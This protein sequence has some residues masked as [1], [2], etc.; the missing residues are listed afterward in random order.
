M[1]STSSGRRPSTSPPQGGAQGTGTHMHILNNKSVR[2]LRRFS[3][4]KKVF[5]PKISVNLCNPWTSFPS[6][7][8][9]IRTGDR[10]PRRRPSA[11]S[12]RRVSGAYAASL[13][14]P[15][16]FDCAPTGDPPIY[17]YLTIKVS[18]D[19]A[20]FHRLKGYLAPKSAL[21]CEI[22]GLLFSKVYAYGY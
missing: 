7:R 13:V 22:C 1:P 21:I 2:R 15:R 17:V 20:D 9:S 18:T 16:P 11:G 14:E 10:G 3:Q 4:I 5:G 6:F 19:Y 8:L 12:G